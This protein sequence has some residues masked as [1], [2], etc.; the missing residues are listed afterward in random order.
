MR[1]LEF[2]VGTH[3]DA[4]LRDGLVWGY[5]NISYKSQ[6]F[7]ALEHQVKYN[8]ALKNK[9]LFFLQLSFFDVIAFCSFLCSLF[10]M[11]WS[12]IIKA[13]LFMVK[14]TAVNSWNILCPF[15]LQGHIIICLNDHQSWEFSLVNVSWKTLWPIVAY[16]RTAHF[17]KYKKI[18]VRFP[19]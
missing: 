15:L 5:L 7:K 6:C 18:V 12:M 2:D 16:I 10:V 19:L 14:E 1:V 8:K 13:L 17:K 9:D 3:I 11:F 4:L